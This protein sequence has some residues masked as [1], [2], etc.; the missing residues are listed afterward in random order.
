MTILHKDEASKNNVLGDVRSIALPTRPWLIYSLVLFTSLDY[1]FRLISDLPSFTILEVLCYFSIALIFLDGAILKDRILGPLLAFIKLNPFLVT[2]FAWVAFVSVV[3]GLYEEKYETLAAFKDLLPSLILVFLI[4]LYAR[5]KNRM[6]GI[7]RIFMAGLLLNLL[8]GCF[9]GTVGMPYPV[10]LNEGAEM[11]IDIDGQ[12]LGQLVVS[13]WFVHPNGFAMYLIPGAALLFA[14]VFGTVRLGYYWRL[15]SF[16]M[17]PMLV[18]CLYRTQGKGAMAWTVA[19]LVFSMVLKRKSFRFAWHFL[20]YSTIGVVALLVIISVTDVTGLKSLRTINTRIELWQAAVHVLR[21]NIAVALTGSGEMQMWRETWMN[22]GGKFPYPNAHNTWLNQA[23]LYGLPGLILYI[24]SILTATRR[25]VAALQQAQPMPSRA[26][27]L[28]APILAAIFALG[29]ENF[30][31]PAAA[32]V[33]LQAQFFLLLGI[34]MALAAFE[35]D[36]TLLIS[37]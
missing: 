23:I 4:F 2:Y 30:F 34:A 27:P 31:E 6:L 14:V 36:M 35:S 28:G 25:L 12:R 26:L 29:G 9:Q 18:F 22:T 20:L 15:L 17:S 8:L 3:N 7:C 10:D 11:K 37:A 1:R 13:G 21:S 32:G 5:N 16:I 33:L 24:L 19:V